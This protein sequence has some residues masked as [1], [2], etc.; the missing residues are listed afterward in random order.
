MFQ[1]QSF[2][3][4][5]SQMFSVSTFFFVQYKKDSDKKILSFYLLFF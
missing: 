3:S 4:L 5:E 1:K 2:M